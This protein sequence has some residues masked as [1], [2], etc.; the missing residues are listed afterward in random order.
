ML[1]SKLILQKIDLMN[2]EQA[3]R[4]SLIDLMTELGF[5]PIKIRKA[6]VYYN[7]PFYKDC[8]TSFKVNRESNVWF[9][10][11]LGK[12]GDVVFF[13]KLYHQTNNINRVLD[14]FEKYEHFI[15]GNELAIKPIKAHV[16]EE[17]VII[18]I[19]ELKNRAFLS[20][21][22]S[23]GID[24]NI[25]KEYCMELRYSI[26]KKE[27]S[28]LTFKNISGGY[29][30]HNPYIRCCIGAR[31]IS[32]VHKDKIGV[33]TSCCIFENHMDFLSYKTLEAQ[34]ISAI[35]IDEPCD[36]IILNGQ[37]NLQNCLERLGSYE[38][39]HCFLHNNQVGRTCTDTIK[40]LYEKTS[41]NESD[42]YEEYLSL[43]RYLQQ[44]K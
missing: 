12:G 29:E 5:N 26:K 40:G 18:S 35:C 19:S 31:H 6:N 16:V 33:Q 38:R 30:I 8:N 11:G 32:I 39:I 23:R 28:A 34:G 13:G 1:K 22:R 10:K 21:L 36:Y 24:P 25:A 15:I 20:Y 42:R 27:Y 43:N 9:D 37:E 17:M 7:S 2:I 14:E 41:I 44:S 4:I 3:N